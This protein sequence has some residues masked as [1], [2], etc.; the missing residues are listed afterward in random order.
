MHFVFMGFET[1]IIS[2]NRVIQLIVV[3]E[4]YCVFFEVGTE[5]LNII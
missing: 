4:I 3:M 5:F 2:L 1:V